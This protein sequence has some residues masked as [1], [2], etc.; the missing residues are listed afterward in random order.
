MS[1]VSSTI[2]E[3]LVLL[4]NARAAPDDLSRRQQVADWLADHDD[5]DRAELVRIQCRLATMVNHARDYYDLVGREGELL[6]RHGAGWL[7]PLAAY[8]CT[9]HRGM[10][11]LRL[12]AAE[13]LS[14]ELAGLAPTATWAWVEKLHLSGIEP[15]HGPAF[16]ASPLLRSITALDLAET[17]LGP[18]AA[19]MLG[20]CPALAGLAELSL[21]GT[22]PVYPY[23]QG[24][25]ADEWLAGVGSAESLP[26]L[27]TLDL[28][29]SG[30]S[31][32]GSEVLVA[33]PLLKSL[34]HLKVGMTAFAN[35][36]CCTQLA[37]SPNAENL[38]TLDLSKTMAWQGIKLLAASKHLGNLLHLD[39][40]DNNLAY[41][42]VGLIA[43]SKAWPRLRSLNLF[44]N[45]KLGPSAAKQ[46]AKHPWSFPLRDL[47][48]RCVGI[49]DKGIASLADAPHVRSLE[50]LNL[51]GNAIG[52]NGA[53]AL[54]ASPHFA[55]L[56]ELD[57]SNNSIGPD[58]LEALA[59]SPHLAGL[60]K[61]SLSHSDVGTQ[62]LRTIAASAHLRGLVDL[63]LN[64]HATE[65]EDYD[66]AIEQADM[67]PNVR[68]LSLDGMLWNAE[69]LRQLLRLPFAP[70]LRELCLGTWVKDDPWSVL[71]ECPHLA[72]LTVL[73]LSAVNV[74]DQ[75]AHQLAG[76]PYL[77]RLTV[78]DLGHN[79]IQP[80]AAEALLG[81]PN[82]PRLRR[83]ILIGDQ[84]EAF[85]ALR[86]RYGSRLD[87]TYFQYPS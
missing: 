33:S 72:N 24:Y 78:L 30:L 16:A 3:L 43:R 57:L 64:R 63:S 4:Q 17:T 45:Q 6:N 11:S 29:A 50:V 19:R 85:T 42:D 80:C 27:A 52:P 71:A 8:L 15:Q 32:P 74:G 61:L 20:Q 28:T 18:E 39:L 66:L 70:H 53:A 55:G 23:M 60:R 46:L 1:R 34:T 12:T 31:N 21:S 56:V 69:R 62:C 35:R 81:A 84:V 40:S 37:R 51:W 41:T 76:S 83:L 22:S 25:L 2:R 14:P 49:G 68:R 9:F 54:A 38:K 48:L 36:E 59:A 10:L 82:L 26:P 5:G 86:R 73:N 75:A 87:Y 47:D 77:R 7:G 79:R 67:L 65:P 58:G 13:L 44:W